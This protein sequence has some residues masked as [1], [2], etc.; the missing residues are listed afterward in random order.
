M[1]EVKS[2]IQ[3]LKHYCDMI[4]EYDYTEKK[5]FIHY[6]LI[7]KGYEDKNYTVPE[8]VY[9]FKEKYK[10]ETNEYMWDNY[11]NSEYLQSFFESG[12]QC[13][14]FEIQFIADNSELLWYYIRVERTQKDKAIISGK[15]MY[16][17]FKERSLYHSIK[18]SFENIISIDVQARTC[19]I[20]H[21][22]SIS[23]MPTRT[24]DYENT[25]K[26]FVDNYT[27]EDDKERYKV[28]MSID[29]VTKK[30]ADLREYSVYINIKSAN[31]GKNC[32]KITFSYADKAKKFITLSTLNIGEIVGRYEHLL[33]ESRKE[34]FTDK[35]TATYNRNYYEKNIKLRKFSGGIAVLDIDDFKLCND[36]YG[37]AAGD[38]ALVLVAGLIKEKLSR[39]DMIIRFGG[40]EFLIL[41]PYITSEG[42]EK[43]LEEIQKSV[44]ENNTNDSEI[45][46]ISLSIGGVVAK[47]EI[48]QEAVY[49]ADRLM[50]RAKLRKN[51]FVT[52]KN[53]YL[54]KDKDEDD[55]INGQ[56][57]IVD[58]SPLNREIL[59]HMLGDKFGVIEASDGREC[60]KLLKKYGT[61]ISLILLDVIMPNMDGFEVL[62]EMNRLHYIDEIPVII[63]TVDGTD[64]NIRRAL[65]LGAAECICRP[66]D[67]KIVMQRIY[68]TV[69]LY[70]KQRRLITMIARQMSESESNGHIMIDVLSGILG[71][72]NGESAMHI[73]HMRKITAMLLERLILKT[74]KYNLSWRDCEMISEAAVLHDIGKIEIE[75]EILNKPGKLTREEREKIKKH[76][77]IGEEMILNGAGESIKNEPMLEIAAAICRS[78]HERYDGSGYP[79]GL[80][81]EDIPIAAQVVSLAD[82]YDALASKRAYKMA[83]SA[84]TAIKMILSGECGNF[85]PLLIECLCDINDKLTNDI[86]ID[87]SENQNDEN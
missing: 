1:S 41:M 54:Q 19:V 23:S 68:N 51:S 40:D 30:L 44:A 18:E 16:D 72:R 39:D 17:E 38:T 4:W 52:E 70:S 73:Q 69:K 24:Y 53:F 42:L 83:Y 67:S 32:K 22:K 60:M 35:L 64:E 48:A 33:T 65:S 12:R 8:I 50:Y 45:F 62:S 29:Y 86:Y 34:N 20:I 66:Y 77:L 28:E 2:L 82:A 31:G 14:E 26:V 36:T 78:H 5:I 76:T 13:D 15:N 6:D 55:D 43:K 27:V 61:G 59:S 25:M 10:L 79:D 87:K 75:S 57:M 85:N 58:D 46:S 63:I 21:A 80:S 56:V 9:T 49:R 81:G 7:A 11:L 3:S 47:N 71:R 74:D 37:H 84:D